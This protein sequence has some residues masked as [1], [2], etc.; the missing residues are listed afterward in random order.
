MAPTFDPTTDFAPINAPTV[1]TQAT[2]KPIFNAAL[3]FAPATPAVKPG[4][5]PNKGMLRNAADKNLGTGFW[6]TLGKGA[7]SIGDAITSSEQKFGKSIADAL[8]AFVP[9]SAAWTNEQNRQIAEQQ[10]TIMEGLISKRRDLV[11]KG[12]DTSHID[13][14]M[15]Q[16]Q[17]DM[18]HPAI[19]IN[20][21]NAS[22]NKSAKQVFG[23]GLGVAAD[24]ASAG[25]YG[26]AASGSSFLSKGGM[27][28]KAAPVAENVAAKA[29]QTALGS[30]LKGAYKGAKTG[31]K[32]GVTYGGLQ[33]TARAMQNNESTGDIVKAGVGGAVVGGVT[34]GALGAV[35]GGVGGYFD[36]S[37]AI[38]KLAAE[39]APAQAIANDPAK[40]AEFQAQIPNNIGYKDAVAM[41]TTKDA[42]G[43]PAIDKEIA[44][45][46]FKNGKLSPTSEFTPEFAAGRIDDTAAE[47]DRTFGTGMGD[48][49]RAM[50]D[51]N[52]SSAQDLQDAVNSVVENAKNV[53]ADAIKY[54]TVGGK[55]VVDQNANEALN[56]GLDSR[57]V[58]MIKNSPAGNKDAYGRMLN[59]AKNTTEDGSY[60]TQP[61]EVPGKTVI[62]QNQVLNRAK[63]SI[64]QQLGALRKSQVF[65]KPID[66]SNTV[67]DFVNN[68]SDSGI[69]VT[70][71]GTLDFSASRYAK[72]P[73]VQ[74]A[75]QNAYEK[76][77]SLDATQVP[78]KTADLIKT[79]LESELGIASGNNTL[80][81]NAN[82]ILNGLYRGLGDDVGQVDPRYADLSAR[83]SQISNAQKDMQSMLGKDFNINDADSA[84]R[85]GEVGRRV[86]G[87]AS[88]KVQRTL[89]NTQNLAQQ[90]G[91]SKDVD[92]YSQYKFAQFLQRTF[93]NTQEANLQ[94]S[95]ERANATAV[96]KVGLKA[97]TGDIA[98]AAMHTVS[99]IKDNIEN[100]SPERQMTAV[101]NLIKG[102]QTTDPEATNAVVG[103]LERVPGFAAKAT[104]IGMKVFS[105]TA[106][107]KPVQRV[108]SGQAGKGFADLMKQ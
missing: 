5:D 18:S 42:Q 60:S 85:A 25:S 73:E 44:S 70:P 29:S 100:I 39:S 52:N 79:Q 96:G 56:S 47:L 77:G 11:A 32:L 91:F 31:V 64:G 14:A 80:D 105:K 19:D 7:A 35:G 69:T 84:L 53:P 21:T 66:I 3:D 63:S 17:Q 43:N 24:I 48:H 58:A 89:T 97:L 65:E 34:G 81:P 12:Q 75:I 30:V 15:K 72:L 87:N 107:S 82:R 38:R 99:A 22:V 90:Y 98:S 83:Y 1:N 102:V 68:L 78:A 27:L 57:D 51:V 2:K 62:E 9:G 74:N 20:E 76:V 93:G 103:A 55:Q 50:V 106:T 49:F 37:S 94:G 45:Q 13:A 108:V 95:M 67:G 4:E 101:E 59:I 40:M 16:M 41:V 104:G 10:H 33:G 23:E 61:I 71:D 36:R 26:K 8:P 54:T 92:T 46:I 86:M 28:T 88:A 6:A